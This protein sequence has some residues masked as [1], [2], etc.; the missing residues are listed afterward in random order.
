[1]ED[2]VNADAEVPLAPEALPAIELPDSPLSDT[3]PAGEAGDFLEAT[4]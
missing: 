2:T 3:P 4:E 1:M